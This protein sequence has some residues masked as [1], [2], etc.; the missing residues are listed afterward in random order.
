MSKFNVSVD[1][2]VL[3]YDYDLEL[4]V[5][6]ITKKEN[7][8][9]LN[10]NKIQL[11]LPGDLIKIDE[12]VDPAARRI[13]NNLTSINEIFLK[14][15]EIFTDPNRV[16]KTK[17]QLWLKNYRKN[18][19]ERVITIGYISLVNIPD[20][21]PKASSFADDVR[22]VPV[23][24]LPELT[25]DHNEIVE[26]ALSFL[27]KELNHEMSS[28]LL[29][30]NFTIPQLQKLYEDVLNKKFDRRNFR[31]QVLRKGVLIK[32]NNTNK[33]GLT[34]KPATLYQF[35]EVEAKNKQYN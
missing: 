29:P 18:P 26:G 21:T 14:R 7:P 33:T 19:N 20:F 31:K 4:K 1:C 3:G 9:N 10:N 8:K 5:L 11:A 35:E 16:K 34:G 32:T 27:K 2:V 12:R 13:L 17:D 6:L 24:N 23:N 22:W 15:F 30:K 25:F 28:F